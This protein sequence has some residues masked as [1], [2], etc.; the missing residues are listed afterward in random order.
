MNATVLGIHPDKMSSSIFAGAINSLQHRHLSF[1]F[2]V[3]GAATFGD[4][5]VFSSYCS[6]SYT[7]K[8]KGYKRNVTSGEESGLEQGNT[9]NFAELV[10]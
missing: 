2:K 1:S 8:R 10:I 3:E 5:R 4:K 7:R 9:I 6:Y